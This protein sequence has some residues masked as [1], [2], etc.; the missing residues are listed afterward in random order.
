MSLKPEG[1]VDFLHKIS[2][3]VAAAG[4]G[5]YAVPY[6][7]LSAWG[8]LLLLIGGA[9]GGVGVVGSIAQPK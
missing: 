7:A 9:L 2:S 3:V 5:L 4:A 6:P 8:Q 1:V